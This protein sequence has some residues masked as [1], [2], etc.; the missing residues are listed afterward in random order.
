MATQD[1]VESREGMLARL[2]GEQA[3]NAVLNSRRIVPKRHW[4]AI[5][6]EASERFLAPQKPISGAQ[7]RLFME[8]VLKRNGVP[9]LSPRGLFI[10]F[11]DSRIRRRGNRAEEPAPDS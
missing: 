3:S 11:A 7:V 9:L 4:N 1:T 8:D 5:I 10:L 6:E 2:I